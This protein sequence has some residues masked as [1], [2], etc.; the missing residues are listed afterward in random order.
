MKKAAWICPGLLEG[1]GGIRTVVQNA[2]F[3]ANNGFICDVYLNSYNEDATP[4][5]LKRRA[6]ELYGQS[7]CNFYPN[8][9]NIRGDYDIV[10][11][12]IYWSAQIIKNLG[13][14]AKKA[15]FVQDHE[16]LFSPM[17]AEH[18]R[19]KLS[20]TYGLYA[21]T[22]GRWLKYK[23]RTEYGVDAQHFDFCADKSIYRPLAKQRENSLCFIYQPGKPNR[24]A[25]LGLEALAIV[26]QLSPDT[27]IYI[28]GSNE[29]VPPSAGAFPHEFLGLLS[30]EE[31]NELYNKCAAGLC[32]SSTNP[33]RIPFEMMSAGLPVVDLYME[34][35]LYDLPAS[36]V[37]LAHYT[38]ESIALALLSMLEDPVVRDRMSASGVEFMKGKDLQHGF[39][40]FLTAVENILSG[41]IPDAEDCAPIYDRQA[42]DIDDLSFT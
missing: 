19:A 34:N 23:L 14:T 24:C 10:F 16:P 31:C 25:P 42:V 2:D 17:G 30:I 3:L 38:P 7:R 4:V 8:I 32:L 37:A 6:E 1:S 28:Y 36:A 21:V 5:T 27:K 9:A 29:K 13:V 11:A 35:N 18:L 40:Q 39:S 41:S 26:S 22:I 12:T 15:Y 33:S 20:Y